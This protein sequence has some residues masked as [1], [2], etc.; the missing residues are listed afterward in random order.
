MKYIQLS[1]PREHV[2]VLLLNRPERY[3]ALSPSSRAIWT[4][5]SSS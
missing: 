5:E 1:K 3:N 4:R 2:A